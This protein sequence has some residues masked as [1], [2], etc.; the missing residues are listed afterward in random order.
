MKEWFTVEQID[1]H[2][3]VISEYRHWEETHCYLLEGEE[4]ALLIDTGLGVKDISEIVQTLTAKPVLAVATHVHWDHIGCH[5]SFS[6]IGVHELEQSWLKSFPVPL[7]AVRSDLIKGYHD[8]P[9]G[10]DPSGFTV[11]EGTANFILRDGDTIDLGGRIVNVIHTPGH[12]PGHMCFY[13]PSKGYL[14]SG[15]LLYMGT[16]F[17]FYPS[18]DP[19]LFASSVEKISAIPVKRLFP[20]HH[21]LNVSPDL[22][23]QAKSAFDSL[24]KDK[25]LYQGSGIHDFGDIKIYI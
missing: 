14:F 23:M 11:F 24:K 5:G 17:A 16:L 1:P 2:T 3:H 20:G 13:E 18:T 21:E 22:I 10:F 9:K 12:S 19:T 6:S 4:K 25:K 15:D 7:T 8:F